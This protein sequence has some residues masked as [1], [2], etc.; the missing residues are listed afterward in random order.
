MEK[1][2]KEE[3]VI[4]LGLNLFDARAI[5][6]RRDGKVI[7]EIEKKH[8]VDNANNTIKIL[9][10]LLEDA[11][12][13]AGKHKED[14]VRVGIAL[15][16]IVHKKKEVIFWPQECASYVHVTFPLKEHLEK[17]FG[18]PVVIENDANACAWAEYLLNFS[19]QKNILYLFS[20]VGCGMV[21]EGK[22]HHGK[23][24]VAGEPFLASSNNPMA[25]RLGDFNFLHQ[26]PADLYMV[27]RA[28]ELIS[29]G[30]D[31]A[32]IKKISST[33]EL[34]LK[35]ILREANKKDRLAREVMREAAFALGV[36]A[37]FL[38]NLLDPEA[39][40]IGGGLED[41]DE[42]FMEDLS[43]AVKSFSLSEARS[44]CKLVMSPLGK[45]AAS[46]GAAYLAFGE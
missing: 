12:S 3:C 37:A 6:L 17:K 35:D 23:N 34:T 24:G 38:I 13:R 31:S 26:W 46:L 20:G 42:A 28:K 9:F 43:S 32:L 45:K 30:K 22:L 8:G 33:G 2:K 15:G 5:V 11:L 40:I 19:K 27:K 18:L 29:L 1:N 44:G 14:V 25:S 7:A 36:K 10:E 39:V 16:G 21:L 41:G 4:G